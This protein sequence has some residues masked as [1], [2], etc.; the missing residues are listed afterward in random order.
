MVVWVQACHSSRPTGRSP[1]A[2]ASSGL[3]AWLT[4]S[5]EQ[6]HHL[7]DLLAGPV[8]LGGCGVSAVDGLDRHDHDQVQAVQATARLLPRGE[9]LLAVAAHERGRVAEVGQVDAG[10]AGLHQRVPVQG[11][12][13]VD[14]RDDPAVADHDVGVPEVPLDEPRLDDVV[15]DVGVQ[16]DDLADLVVVPADVDVAGLPVGQDGLDD[17]GEHDPPRRVT[18]AG[19]RSE[20]VPADRVQLAVG[21]AER[22]VVRVALLG[23]QAVG[24]DAEVLGVDERHEEV[25]GVDELVA[26]VGV[27]DL[28][29]RDVGACRDQ[30]Q[31][32]ELD[33]HRAALGGHH[34]H[35]PRRRDLHDHGPAVAQQDPVRDVEPAVPELLEP[36]VRLAR[37]HLV[38]AVGTLDHRTQRRGR[39]AVLRDALHRVLI[40]VRRGVRP[41]VQRGGGPVLART[42]SS[43]GTTVR[44][45]GG[46]DRDRS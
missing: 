24:D 15:E 23:A 20:P 34:R 16:G 35:V 7:V 19:E 37:G 46:T 12:F 2:A 28:R 17:A 1:R 39:L 11:A 22:L 32:V 13:V 29:D 33:A 6:A 45:G 27:V 9:L 26:Q 4:G 41:W 44:A 21:G 36:G 3:A 8:V 30:R 40:V 5:R 42:M 10:E 25:V 31:R 14:D 18:R 43:V 38:G